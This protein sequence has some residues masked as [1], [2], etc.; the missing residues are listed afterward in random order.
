MERRDKKENFQPEL[1]WLE[2]LCS[3]IVRGARFLNLQW[4]L[5]QGAEGHNWYAPVLNASA[6]YLAESACNLTSTSI[7][8]KIDPDSKSVNVGIPSE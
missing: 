2:S 6:K 1:K 4:E 3:Q 5:M 7:S 8:S